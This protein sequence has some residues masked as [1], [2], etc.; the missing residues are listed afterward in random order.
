MPRLW[1][2][3]F[4]GLCNST[5]PLPSAARLPPE[6]CSWGALCCMQ[7]EKETGGEIC[8]ERGAERR[9]YERVCA[10]NTC[11]S[12]QLCAWKSRC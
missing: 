9:L 1:A 10:Q 8:L 2:A 11:I 3:G 12:V 5:E 6:H 7:G 4:A